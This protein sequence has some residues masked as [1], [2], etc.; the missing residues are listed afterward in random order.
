MKN[1]LAGFIVGSSFQVAYPVGGN[2]N[3]LKTREDATILAAK[4]NK[5][6]NGYVFIKYVDNGDRRIANLSIHKMINPIVVAN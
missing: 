1:E 4:I 3:I 5:R 6:G 2:R